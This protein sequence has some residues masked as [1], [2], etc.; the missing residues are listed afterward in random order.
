MALS[1]PV[2]VTSLLQNEHD[3]AYF[4]FAERVDGT[5]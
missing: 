4:E 1:E 2:R 5:R 3:D